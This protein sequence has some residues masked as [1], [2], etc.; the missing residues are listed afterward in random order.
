MLRHVAKTI[1][2][3]E[4]ML[5]T[6]YQNR[7]KRNPHDIL[8]DLVKK[9]QVFYDEH[10]ELGGIESLQLNVA[11]VEGWE[12]GDSMMFCSLQMI[13]DPKNP[14]KPVVL[15]LVGRFVPHMHNPT[16]DINL[17]WDSDST[18]RDRL[19]ECMWSEE[20]VELWFKGREESPTYLEYETA[21][22]NRRLRA[23]IADYHSAPILSSIV[24]F[25]PH[26]AAFINFMSVMVF[27]R[28]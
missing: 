8:N 26:Q 1:D 12:M 13:Q 20:D 28:L 5:F 9:A 2:E 16:K 14:W 15:E 7:E 23:L 10:I 6:T 24:T 22:Y 25:Q 19:K 18:W 27:R 4:I 11:P 21:L 3:V 17:K